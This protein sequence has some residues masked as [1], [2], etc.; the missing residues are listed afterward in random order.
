MVSKRNL[1]YS[2]GGSKPASDSRLKV[3]AFL[4]KWKEEIIRSLPVLLCCTYSYK[5]PSNWFSVHY[6]F[7]V[8]RTSPL[9]LPRWPTRNLSPLSPSCPPPSTSTSTSTSHASEPTTLGFSGYTDSTSR[10]F[11]WSTED[12]D[13]SPSR[14][15]SPIDNQSIFFLTSS[16]TCTKN[17]SAAWCWKHNATVPIIEV[18]LCTFLLRWCCTPTSWGESFWRFCVVVLS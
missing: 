17:L 4:S 8:I 15:R 3:L 18:P 1:K 11:Q 2:Y 14:H 12:E 9:Q 16:I 10:P 7:R 5:I 6:L 13:V